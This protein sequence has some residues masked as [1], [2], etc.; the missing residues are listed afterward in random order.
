MKRALALAVV[1]A[2]VFVMAT[3]AFADFSK[4]LD[5]AY[6][7]MERIVKAPMHLI[8][9]PQDEYK[10]ATFKPFGLMGGIL[11]GIGYTVVESVYG[12]MEVVTSPF[13][14]LEK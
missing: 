14:L 3:P 9:D 1:F 6:H 13:T 4:P 2:F 7:G 12:V 10:A 8:N 5:K 11:K